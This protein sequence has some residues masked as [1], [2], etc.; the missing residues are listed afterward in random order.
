MKL[1]ELIRTKQFW[2]HVIIAS[3]CGLALLFGGFMLLDVYT[4]HGDEVEVPDF[5]GIYIKDLEKFVE[6][7]DLNFEIVDS[8][9]SN[10]SAKGTV[11]DQD[12]NSGSK[13]KRN[14]VIYLTVNAM[15]TKKV[16]MPDLIDLSLKQATS[17]LETYGLKIGSIRY[18][19]G[20]P[21][22][23]SQSFRGKSING[24]ELIDIGSKIDLVLGRGND[25]GLISIPNLFGLTLSEVRSALASKSLLLGQITE[26]AGVDT[27]VAKVWKQ[28]PSPETTEGLYD[29][30]K[31]NVWITQSET[32]LEDS[33]NNT[34]GTYR[35]E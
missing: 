30:A 34:D 7:H 3:V 26:D 18:V 13:V 29:G 8:V 32:L 17:L 21:P 15:L 22:V 28:N 23:M 11:I 6:G 12:P 10:E 25:G 16:K 9:Y 24:G 19:E 20:L 2:K 31:I 1:L 14:R 33:Q 27:T 5:A 4:Q 35:N